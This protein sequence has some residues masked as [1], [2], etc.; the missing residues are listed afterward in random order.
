MQTI[1]EQLP[2]LISQFQLESSMRRTEE[3]FDK[4]RSAKDSIH[5]H[6]LIREAV[7]L[8]HKMSNQVKPVSSPFQSARPVEVKPVSSPS[9]STC[10]VE[11]KHALSPPQSA[12]PMDG[13]T[14]SPFVFHL[15]GSPARQSIYGFAVVGN[16]V[17]VPS[18]VSSQS[19][20]LNAHISVY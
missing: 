16:E 7:L 19:P 1:D 2:S 9:Q 4:M 20:D 6:E 14:N 13:D 5:F 3:M 18:S 15:G 11:V 17:F 10:P 8:L 12:C